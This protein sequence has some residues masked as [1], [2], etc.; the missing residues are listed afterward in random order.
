MK[1]DGRPAP[2]AMSATSDMP[3]WMQDFI[4]LAQFKSQIFLHG[5]VKDCAYYPRDEQGQYWELQLVRNAVMALLMN[6][7]GGYAVI[8]SYDPVDGMVF[9][10]DSSAGSGMAQVYVDM[11]QNAGKPAVA[12]VP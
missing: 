4:R 10:D 8:G 5:N 9:A 12:G 1:I 7:I 11:S 2:L 3:R 6:H